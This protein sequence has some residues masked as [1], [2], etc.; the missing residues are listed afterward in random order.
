MIR[1]ILSVFTVIV[2]LLQYLTKSLLTFILF[3]NKMNIEYRLK[4]GKIKQLDFPLTTML[5]ENY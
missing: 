1:L 2:D 3:E 4:N 5:W